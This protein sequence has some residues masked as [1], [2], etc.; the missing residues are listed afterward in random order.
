MDFSGILLGFSVAL[1]PENLL[2]CLIGTAAGT[3]VGVLPGIGPLAGV[4]VLLPVT[5]G[6][7]PVAALIMLAKSRNGTVPSL[8]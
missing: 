1:S 7:P 3:L 5:Y 2:Y 8:R 4:A 6:L